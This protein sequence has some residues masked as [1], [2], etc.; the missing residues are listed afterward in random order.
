MNSLDGSQK[1]P[2]ILESLIEKYPPAQLVAIPLLFVVILKVILDW[3]IQKAY[4]RAL[5]ENWRSVGETGPL[6]HCFLQMYYDLELD[7]MTFGSPGLQSKDS[8]VDWVSQ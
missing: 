7:F 2:G 4:V 1:P 5:D 6:L 8:V 3:P